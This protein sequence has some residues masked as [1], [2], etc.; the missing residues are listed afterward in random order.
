MRCGSTGFVEFVHVARC[1]ALF[2]VL[3]AVLRWSAAC[4]RGRVRATLRLSSV[5]VSCPRRHVPSAACV[6]RM[7]TSSCSRRTPR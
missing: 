6:P 3:C 4:Q 2:S 5:T 7:R 1:V